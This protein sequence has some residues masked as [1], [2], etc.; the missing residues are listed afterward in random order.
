MKLRRQPSQSSVDYANMK[1]K[2]FFNFYLFF[3]HTIHPDCSF[4]SHHSSQ[5]CPHL[6]STQDP[7]SAP[8]P[9]RKEQDSQGHQWNIT[10][11]TVRPGTSRHI[12]AGQ[13][14]PVGL[15]GSQA[16]AKQ[17]EP[18]PLALSGVPPQKYQ[19]NHHNIYA[20]DQNLNSQNSLELTE[21]SGHNEV[22][23]QPQG[24]GGRDRQIFGAY[25]T[26]NLSYSASSRPMRTCLKT[27]EEPLRLT[28]G[29]GTRMHA[30]AFLRART[31]S[32]TGTQF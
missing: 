31:R 18:P 29:T 30:C 22:D 28:S 1:T 6:P 12:K 32:H 25:R 3:P 2:L 13:G 19:A 17:S 8:P 27:P 10:Q 21:K 26:A 16:Q 14:N 11:D 9:P 20:E 15:K 24:C 7:L 23:A 5:F 4:P